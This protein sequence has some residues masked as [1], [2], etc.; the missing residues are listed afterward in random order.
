LNLFSPRVERTARG[1]F[2][3]RLSAR[4]REILRALPGQLRELL[5]TDDP[6]LHRLFPPAYDEGSE[7]QAEY[8]SLVRGEL[9]RDRLE[10]L[11]VMEGTMDARRLTE[12]EMTA[13]LGALNDL[14]LVLGT[15]LEVT[16]EMYEEGLPD[17]D[18]RA[19][20]FALYT[21]LGWLEEQV[22]EALAGGPSASEE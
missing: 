1:D 10:A 4:E 22:V 20:S 6:A 16:E 8:A 19:E 17:D 7:R 2:R 21:Y 18:P 9:L 15:R 11:A 13:W 3:L 14:R 12:E 5:G